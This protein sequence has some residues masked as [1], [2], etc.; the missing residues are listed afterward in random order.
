MITFI[1]NVFGRLKS[2]FMPYE[3]THDYLIKRV[4]WLIGA[5]LTLTLGTMIF[6]YSRLPDIIIIRSTIY[7]GI[8]LIGARAYSLAIPLAAFLVAVLHTALASLL[9]K[10]YKGLA[11]MLLMG[12]VVVLLFVLINTIFIIHLNS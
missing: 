9:Y 6:S 11:R 8:D 1:Y 12:T 2:I 7:F 10:K 3:L 4:L 5:L